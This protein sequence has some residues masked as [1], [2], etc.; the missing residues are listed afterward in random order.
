MSVTRCGATTA[1]F[2]ANPFRSEP[3]PKQ[4]LDFAFQALSSVG[5]PTPLLQRKRRIAINLRRKM[6]WPAY[7][8]VVLFVLN[9]RIVKACFHMLPLSSTSSRAVCLSSMALL[10]LGS[11]S[12]LLLCTLPALPRSDKYPRCGTYIHSA[13]NPLAPCKPPLSIQKYT[14]CRL[15]IPNTPIQRDFLPCLSHNH[16]T[17]STSPKVL[18]TSW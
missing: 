12:S 15:P 3:V 11:L 16:P 10:S 13:S 8:V 17:Q 14:S 2:G 7:S 18:V 4:F 5:D 1:R 9:S 6:S